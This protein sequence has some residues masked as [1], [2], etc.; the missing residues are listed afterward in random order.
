[1]K[2]I[3]KKKKLKYIPKVIVLVLISTFL[4]S[5]VF[6][7]EGGKF[8]D[9]ETI[10][11]EFS[12]IQENNL[13]NM[14]NTPKS[15]TTVTLRPNS[16]IAPYEWSPYSYTY[17]DDTTP[18]NSFIGTDEYG[19]NTDVEHGYS[20]MP[21]DTISVSAITFYVRA[22]EFLDCG[23]SMYP[24]I[25]DAYLSGYTTDVTT[26]WVTYSHT[27]Y[28]TWTKTA[29]D[30]M[31]F[32]LNSIVRPYLDA[33]CV[34][35]I[36]CVVT[37]A[38]SLPD[39]PASPTN[40]NTNENPCYDGTA[41]ITWTKSPGA[42]KY[43]LYE[44]TS[45]G[46]TYSP[47]GSELGDVSSTTVSKTSEQ[48]R[49]YKVTAGNTAG[50]SGYS[51][52]Y[53]EISWSKPNSPTL[54]SP[55]TQ[56]LYNHNS[57]SVTR[58]SVGSYVDGFDWEVSIDGGTYADWSTSSLS[59]LSYNPPA[60]DH[61][62]RFRLR[63][64]NAN[65]G[66]WSD[67]GESGIITISSPSTPLNFQVSE[68][69][70]Y[71]GLVTFSW[72]ATTGATSYS[73][74]EATTSDG[75]YTEIETGITESTTQVSKSTENILYYKLK[76]LN[77]VGES[78]FSGFIEV[79]WLKPNSPT[80]S[81]PTTQTIY[82]HDSISVIRDSVGAY[83]D[84][85]D[86]EVSIDGGTYADWSTSSLSTLSYNPPAGDHTYQFRLRVRNVNF[87]VWS[88]YGESGI[89]TISSPSTPLN[90]QVSEETCYDGLV[91][92]SWT[93]T[94]GATS[95]S[96]YE[97]TTSDGTYTEIETG[98][99]ESTTQVSKSAENILYYKLKAL[100]DVGESDFSGFIEVTWSK[101]DSPTLTSPT[102]ETVYNLD[103]ISVI[104]D[105][106]GA[107]VD[108]YDWEVSIDGEAYTDWS[109]SSLST[110]SYNPPTGDHTYQF[111]L[112]VRNVNFGVWSDY[113]ESGIITVSLSSIPM[114][115]QTSE[116]I[117]YDGSV[118]ISWDVVTGATNYT[119]YEATTSDG[120][121]TPIITDII[122][123][124]IIISKTTIETKYYKIKAVNQVGESDFSEYVSVSWSA[125]ET[126][127][128]TSPIT[129]VVDN[130]SPFLVI[131][132]SVG[133]YVDEFNWEICIDGGA[134][135]N[136][137]MSELN[138]L[139]YDPVAE[140][141]TYQFRLRVKNSEFGIWSD[142]GYSGILTIILLDTECPLIDSPA[143]LTYTYNT[144]G[145]NIT[146]SVS[147]SNPYQYQ[148]FINGIGQ[149]LNPW[150]GSNLSFNVDGFSIGNYN[151]TLWVS[152]IEGN[153]AQDQ[154][155]VTVESE[156]IISGYAI[157]SLS[158]IFLIGVFMS[159]FI[160]K[161]KR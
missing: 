150:D 160:I 56:T 147:D 53:A 28:G 107:Y 12:E 34:D 27:W 157:G 139:S 23:V 3:S 14:K 42:T 84:G 127:S 120:T 54:S 135:V 149:G 131:R 143:D 9:D 40:V 140:D 93:A 62:Y 142:Y 32:K 39:P 117:C 99:I 78:D 145:H 44:A 115:V 151:V 8:Q 60:G 109:T 49:F 144:I 112:S 106:V 58:A 33:L 104:R 70:C 138:N 89:I 75:T 63:V 67:Y 97:A 41:S 156:F 16:N 121:Y 17:V 11:K 114:N 113:G 30:G 154:V 55:T 1:M 100:N 87:G 18:D 25:S 80:L 153:W 22:R 146:W 130:D 26:S 101:P 126:P 136:W 133:V 158:A 111:R 13:E 66:V 94:T 24:K 91:T 123:T 57:F 50:W 148:L 79:S 10:S 45:S 81:S 141:H 77:D 82:N 122:E 116:S 102:T 110:L 2:K 137:S 124:S 20:N 128:I 38:S 5:D 95:Y 85:F 92:F 155:N 61:T 105:S 21:S 47:I 76:A 90:F 86:W 15:S 64:R 36:Y 59:T 71:D 161:R 118:Q 43:Q 51:S 69:T 88:D 29:I 152:D 19:D 6:L 98:I 35:Q 108:E 96:L 132:D 48:T 37:Y 125:P 74:Y 119:L 7:S 103:S 134:Y 72:T 52:S 129:E 4:F 159:I 65:F 83:V 68:E 31:S 73:L 46:G